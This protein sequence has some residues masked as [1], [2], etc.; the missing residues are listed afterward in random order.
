MTEEH[1]ADHRVEALNKFNR[2][3]ADR[4]KAI[5]AG[6]EFSKEPEF[7]DALAALEAI[8]KADATKADGD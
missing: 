2:L 7:Q 8:E 3:K 5:V 1:T 6:L 4:L